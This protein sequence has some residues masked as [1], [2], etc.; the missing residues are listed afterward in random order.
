MNTKNNDLGSSH[1]A[2]KN[3]LTKLFMEASLIYNLSDKLSVI[4]L[5]NG[6]VKNRIK[7]SMQHRINGTETRY[8]YISLPF[9][10]SRMFFGINSYILINIGLLC[11]KKMFLVVYIEKTITIKNS[12]L[13]NNEKKECII[14]SLEKRV[15]APWIKG[16]RNKAIKKVVIGFILINVSLHSARLNISYTFN[17]D[18]ASTKNII[19]RNNVT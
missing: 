6:V 13:S 14:F 8:M 12:I 7:I 3:R 10:M 16:I 15:I 18:S 4:L 9:I 5:Y 19:V 17:F 11:S 1:I 2:P